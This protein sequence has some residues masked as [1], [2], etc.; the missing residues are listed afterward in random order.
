MQ[1]PQQFVRGLL[2][3]GR[4]TFTL[5]QAAE[6][7]GRQGPVLNTVLQRLKRDGWV[8]SFSRGFYLVLDVQHQAAGM[9][10]PKW[11]VD[12]WTKSLRVEYYVGGLSAAELHGA[13][14][15][16]PM[17]F[18]VVANRQLH[19]IGHPKFRMDI[20][21]KKKI[22]PE[23]WEQKKSP[24]G[25]FR[26]SIPEVT[27]YDV[28]AYHRACPSLD[29]AATVM[30]ELGEV[31]RSDALGRLPILGCRL[32]V[33]QRLGWLLNR[34][35]WREKADHLAEALRG[36]RLAWRPL[37]K[38]LPAEGERDKRWKIIVNTDVQP[39]IEP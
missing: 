23:M 13:A 12:D 14:H 5:E 11:F 34:T 26:V 24:A 16:R 19:T 29:H 37:E 10:D 18:Q 20:M 28:V 8:V 30:V 35:G 22:I 9:L 33:L 15:Q 1:S 7:L 36:K 17:V 39:D 27:A 21:Y 31:L 32:P 25:Y 3:R 4:Y 6:A 2:S 38:R